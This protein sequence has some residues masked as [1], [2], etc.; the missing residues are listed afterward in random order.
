MHLIS[1]PIYDDTTLSLFQNLVED[2]ESY[3]LWSYPPDNMNQFL[4]NTNCK[5]PN[6]FLGIKDLLDSWI[7]FDWW[8]DRQQAGSIRIQ[9]FARRHPDQQIVLFTSLER[10]EREIT[11]PNLHII[12]WGG[13]WL[14]QRTEYTKLRP[15]LEKN[16]SSD[17]TY[18][19]LNRN[20]RSH[21]VVILSYLLG[22]G[23]D[24]TGVLT[25]LKN[26][27]K[28]PDTF[29]KS[30]GWQFDIPRHDMIRESI[31]NG[32]NRLSITND[33]YEIYKNY[34]QG[35]TDNAG[36]FENKLRSMY[37][38]SFVEIVSETT[39]IEPSFILSEKTAHA[40]YGCNFPII[41][42]GCG[43]VEHLRDIGLDVF[44]DIVDHSYDLVENPFDR[45]VTAIESNRRLLM[46]TE[47]VKQAWKTN[48]SRFERN[49]EVMKNMYS[50]YENRTRQQFVKTLELIRQQ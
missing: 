13:D 48:R 7:E 22:Q 9:E 34:G 10:L 11:E 33:D 19:N 4:Q 35:H 5:S 14:N 41:L 37:Q 27:Y 12:P 31:L 2:Q 39:F 6:I 23:Y 42:N 30:I 44:D 28:M 49:I 24:T 43:C 21:R 20:V 29:L 40:F 18:I 8:N 26:P 50:W 1:R 3:Y 25:Y 45:I 46:D 15:V 38:N 32:F 36:N 47:Y 17:R 16:F